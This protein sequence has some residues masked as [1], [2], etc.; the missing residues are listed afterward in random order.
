MQLR[1]F[2]ALVPVLGRV[3][4]SANSGSAARQSERPVAKSAA[5]AGGVEGAGE[6]ETWMALG[7]ADARAGRAFQGTWT[8]RLNARNQKAL[9]EAYSRGFWSEFDRLRFERGEYDLL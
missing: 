6:A 1:D 8:E 9:A 2:L 5:A 7:R 4:E 3:V